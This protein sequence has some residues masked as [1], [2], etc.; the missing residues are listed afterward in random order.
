[1]MFHD[2]SHYLIQQ[3][4]INFQLP[5]FF[6]PFLSSQDVQVVSKVSAG[7]LSLDQIPSKHSVRPLEVEHLGEVLRTAGWVVGITF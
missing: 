3:F 2:L 7:L 6:V 1:M 5:F 4:Q